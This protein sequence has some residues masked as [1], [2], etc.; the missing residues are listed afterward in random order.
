MLRDSFAVSTGPRSHFHS[1]RAPVGTRGRRDRRRQPWI[2]CRAAGTSPSGT[3]TGRRPAAANGAR[4]LQDLQ[5]LL[6]EATTLAVATGPRSVTRT[7]QAGGALLEVAREQLQQLQRGGR[8]DAPAV[9]LRKLFERLGAT[10][11]K[12]GQFIASSATLFPVSGWFP[13]VGLCWCRWVR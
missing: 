11:I 2:E 8:P 4:R 3:A 5:E 1:G 13:C 10:Y 6:R 7:A 9:V 12:L